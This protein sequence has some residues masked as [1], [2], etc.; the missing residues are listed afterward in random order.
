MLLQRLSSFLVAGSLL[1]F[2]SCSHVRFEV[3]LTWESRAPDGNPR[4][5]VLINGRF[6][7]PQLDLSFGDTVEVERHFSNVVLPY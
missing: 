7:G 4:Q 5:M 2:G 6:P 1:A 3:E